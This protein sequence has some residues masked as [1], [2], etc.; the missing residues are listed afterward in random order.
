MRRTKLWSKYKSEI[1]MQVRNSNLDHIIDPTYRN[2]NR[3]FALSFKNDSN[4]RFYAV[5]NVD[6]IYIHFL[7]FNTIRA[8]VELFSSNFFNSFFFFFFFFWC[9][10]HFF[11][12]IFIS[13]R[14]NFW[15]S[16]RF[17]AI[18]SWFNWTVAASWKHLSSLL[19]GFIDA[20]LFFMELGD[21]DPPCFRFILWHLY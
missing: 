9:V 20:F 1:T 3:L 13:N 4:D 7:T 6:R 19:I 10:I 15:Q 21:A 8:I 17:F 14:L 2:I 11:P 16:L 5:W 12:V 18:S